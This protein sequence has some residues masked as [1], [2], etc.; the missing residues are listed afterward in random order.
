MALEAELEELRRCLGRALDFVR[1]YGTS[2]A[3]HLD[4]VPCC[5]RD[6]VSFG[7]RRVLSRQC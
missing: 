3:E 1:A 5:V 7:V 6:I 2:L 4:D